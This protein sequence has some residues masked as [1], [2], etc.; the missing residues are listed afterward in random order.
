MS[1][2]VFVDVYVILTISVCLV[3]LASTGVDT[4]VISAQRSK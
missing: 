4:N 1:P 3:V 2:L